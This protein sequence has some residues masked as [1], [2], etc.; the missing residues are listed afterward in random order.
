[1]RRS[2]ILAGVLL[3]TLLSTSCKRSGSSEPITIRVLRDPVFA[4]DLVKTNLEF[5]QSKPHLGDQ[6]LVLANKDDVPYW[7]VNQRLT[8]FKPHVFIFNS[9]DSVPDDPAI[10]SALGYPMLVCGVHT[11]FIPTSTVGGDREAAEIYVR[12]LISHC[13]AVEVR[14]APPASEPEQ[15][16]AHRPPC[17]TAQCQ[18]IKKYLKDHY[19]GESPFGNGPDDGCDYKEPIRSGAKLTV[20]FHCDWN[21]ATAKSSCRQLG[22]PL[23]QQREMLLR[24]LRHVGLPARGGKDVTFSAVESSSGWLLMSADYDHVDRADAHICQVVVAVDPNGREQ[25]LRSVR[26]KKTNSDVPEVTLWSPHDIADVDEDG[27]PEFVLKGDAYE[28]HWLEV[29]KI[30]GNSAKTI[31]SGLGYY[32]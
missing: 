17:L 12:F 7:D 30:Q 9:Q 23:P 6:S 31:F 20:S 3:L 26:M 13:P 28:D 19:C 16:D 1:M 8:G 32:L 2:E 22:Q 4:A 11:A 18:K 29:V 25:V 24:E 10:R 27:K 15:A 5:A 14:Q 21:E